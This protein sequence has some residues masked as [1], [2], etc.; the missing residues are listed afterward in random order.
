M[1]SSCSSISSDVDIILARDPP[2]KMLESNETLAEDTNQNYK[3]KDSSFNGAPISNQGFSNGVNPTPVERR[4]RRRLPCIERPRSA[5]IHTLPSSSD[6][7]RSFLHMLHQQGNN[8]LQDPNPGQN[9][10]KRSSSNTNPAGASSS[11]CDNMTLSS[12]NSVVDLNKAESLF[13]PEDDSDPNG[14]LKTV[15]KIGTNSQSIEHHHH[16]VHRLPSQLPSPSSSRYHHGTISR[17]LS[18]QL[19][20]GMKNNQ[21]YKY[22][23]YHNSQNQGRA[24]PMVSGC[25]DNTPYMTPAQS[26]ENFYSSNSH[27][28]TDLML[29]EA[30]ARRNKQMHEM[31][32]SAESELDRYSVVSE[33]FTEC[34]EAPSVG[35]ISSTFNS[36]GYSSRYQS[37]KVCPNNSSSNGFKGKKPVKICFQF[38]VHL[39]IY[40][41]YNNFDI[42]QYNQ[43]LSSITTMSFVIFRY[44][45]QR[46]PK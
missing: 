17:Q 34:S 43:H 16:H 22:Q 12:S 27:S 35:S 42:N 4:R 44:Q 19:P 30:I 11:S 39:Y 13:D 37:T 38:K 10:H 5:P 1:K 46:K 3:E 23:S 14:T 2:Q 18:H 29:M 45:Q 24:L 32:M 15:I 9:Y 31:S 6:D 41:I 8:I 21:F 25:V 7:E 40:F 20:R 28:S 36:N 33:S 26:V